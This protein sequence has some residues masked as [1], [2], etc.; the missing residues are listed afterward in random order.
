LAR[1]VSACLSRLSSRHPVGE[2]PQVGATRR[3]VSPAGRGRSYPRAPS[4]DR[5]GTLSWRADRAGRRE[6]CQPQ[7]V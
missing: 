2:V 6:H 5:G 4:T 7:R 1:A 3:R